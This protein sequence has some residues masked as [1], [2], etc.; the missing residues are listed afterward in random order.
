V[1]ISSAPLLKE[2]ESAALVR[3]QDCD[4]F[5]H[6][7]N[8]R[9]IDYFMNARQDQLARDYGFDLFALSK[10]TNE[11]WVVTKTQIAYLS[12]ALLMEEVLIQTRLIHMSE[13][14]LVVEGLMLNREAAHLKAVT[15]IEFAFVSLLTGKRSTH[16]EDFMGTFGAVV[17]EGIYGQHGFNSRVDALKRQFRRAPRPQINAAA[18]NVMP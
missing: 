9:Y 16:S 17:V 3:F 11:G 12:P 4:P 6:L 7:N 18:V 8:A 1:E 5:G 15:W 13:S 2:L 10:Q 14:A